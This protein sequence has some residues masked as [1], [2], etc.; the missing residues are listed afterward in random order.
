MG[1]GNITTV[2]NGHHSPIISTEDGENTIN[3][4]D[5]GDYPYM[6]CYIEL[7]EDD[8][9]SVLATPTA[10]TIEFQ[11]SPIG[12]VFLPLESG[13]TINA[14]DVNNGQYV[15]PVFYGHTDTAKVI[16][17]GLQNAP[18]AKIILWRND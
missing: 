12:N 2:R 1:I 15:P 17:N 3:L 10:G 13:G 5:D 18:F 6:H 11:A 7:Y 4:F 16:F 9:G 8:S 14:T